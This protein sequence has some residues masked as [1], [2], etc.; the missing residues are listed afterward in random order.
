MMNRFRSTI[1]IVLICF[2][3]IP[4]V[5]S[6]SAQMDITGEVSESLSVKDV[7]PL[8]DWNVVKPSSGDCTYKIDRSSKVTT[9]DSGSSLGD[10]GVLSSA[11][12]GS[13][14]V[15]GPNEGISIDY[16]KTDFQDSGVTMESFRDDQGGSLSSD[17]TLML[18][19]PLTV[20]V[21]SKIKVSDNAG[22]GSH[23]ATVDITVSYQ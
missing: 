10:C 15:T 19:S 18:S 9:V 13:F 22:T 5:A 1:L 6:D 14:T 23:T 4:S 11:T 7:A 20:N 3:T 12:G 16:S 2:T 21:G 8:S 17:S